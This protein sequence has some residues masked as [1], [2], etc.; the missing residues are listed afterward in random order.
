[1]N[2]RKAI[3]TYL[4]TLGN[5][6]YEPV[7]SHCTI[8]ILF[9]FTMAFIQ[10]YILE[11]LKPEKYYDSA[12]SWQFFAILFFYTYNTMLALD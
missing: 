2:T 12:I 7:Y 10:L 1:M 8:R 5:G 9:T 6:E 3:S 11:S 4:L